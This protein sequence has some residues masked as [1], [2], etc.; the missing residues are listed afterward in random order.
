MSFLPLPNSM[1]VRIQLDTRELQAK[2]LREAL[3]GLVE[4]S[5]VVLSLGE[6]LG[7][8]NAQQHYRKEDI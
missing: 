7:S 3:R 4:Q 6:A 8:R 2:K 1:L 5:P